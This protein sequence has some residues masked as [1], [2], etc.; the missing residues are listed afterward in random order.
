MHAI[1]LKTVWKV[2]IYEIIPL[3]NQPVFI[4]MTTVH[5]CTQKQTFGCKLSTGSF[6]TV[7]SQTNTQCFSDYRLPI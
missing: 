6:I 7:H 3:F 2:F 1:L 5:S 4:T